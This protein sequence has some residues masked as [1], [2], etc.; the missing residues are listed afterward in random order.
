MQGSKKKK[1]VRAVAAAA[2]AVL[3]ANEG[4]YTEN[5]A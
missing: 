5:R 4:K 2:V 3:V 1:N